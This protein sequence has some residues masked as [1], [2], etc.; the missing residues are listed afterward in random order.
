MFSVRCF[1]CPALQI[2][3]SHA[4]STSLARPGRLPRPAPPPAPHRVP[5]ACD[6]RQSA[7]AF[8]Q[9]LSWDTSSVTDMYGMFHV[10]SSPRPAPTICTVAPSHRHARCVHA[11]LAAHPAPCALCLRPRQS[12][13]LPAPRAHQYLQSLALSLA[14]CLCTA[15]APR[16]PGG[17]AA[18]RLPPTGHQLVPHRE[19]CLRPS[20]VR[21]GLQP[22][23]ELGHLPRHEH[24]PYVLR[25]LLP[26]LWPHNLHSRARSL[27][28]CAHRDRPPY[29]RR[30]A[31]ASHLTPLTPSLRLG[32]GPWCRVLLFPVRRQ[33]AA[34]PLRVGG[35]PRLSLLLSP[36][37]F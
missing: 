2:L 33:Q 11:A 3:P 32:T 17:R 8:N 31:R 26:T 30:G 35:H 10:R 24:E 37:R 23:P 4:I 28:R 1:H 7:W 5:C 15:L 34:H 27:A 14:R 22:A 21:A 20:A 9:P 16:T 6:P 13:R 29:T 25:A 18:C 12:A 19:P 36:R